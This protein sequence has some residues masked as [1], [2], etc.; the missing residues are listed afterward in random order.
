MGNSLIEYTELKV[1][2]SPPILKLWGLENRGSRMLYVHGEEDLSMMSISLD[3]IDA[4]SGIEVVKW[5]LGT[6]VDSDDVGKLT[7]PVKRHA[8]GVSI[9]T[10][11]KP[12]GTIGCSPLGVVSPSD[13][14]GQPQ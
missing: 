10:S 2:S 7:E 11:K 1:D 4:H 9:V 14:L 8:E 3:A 5:Y 12:S 13:D 6:S